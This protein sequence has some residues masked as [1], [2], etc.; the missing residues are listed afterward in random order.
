S[1]I[2]KTP[3][4]G[5]NIHEVRNPF[6]ARRRIAKTFARLSNFVLNCAVPQ[7]NISVPSRQPSS[8]DACDLSV[9]IVSWNVAGLLR[10]CLDALF[11]PEV[12]AGLR[13]EVIVV[14][15]AS[16]DDSAQVAAA[17]E[18]V[19]VVRNCRNIGY[20]SA[21]NIGFKLA[22]GNYLLVLNP[23]TVALPG[24]LEALVA[25]AERHTS[26]GIVAPRLLNPDG[27]I[28]RSAFRFPTLM[29]AFLDLFPLSRVV[30]GRLRNWISHSTING[31][32]PGE[33]TKTQPYR[34]DHPL[35]AAM[36]LRREAIEN[37]GGFDERL[38]MYSEE[39]DLAMRLRQVGWERWQVPAA[40]VIH[41]GG[42]STK[43][44]PD[45]MLRELWR[46]RLYIYEKHHD[47]VSGIFLH[48]LI[49]TAQVKESIVTRLGAALG[50][51]PI[52]E[53]NLR[54]RRARS[55]FRLALDMKR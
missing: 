37:V 54:L 16:S 29:M 53:A 26:A 45:R 24:S 20:G 38:F 3:R 10:D 11:S 22:R 15:N 55:L 43:Q 36:L 17:F 7:S 18:S 28:Q 5:K 1:V 51:M 30:P 32:Y 40:R 34:I 25:F 49:I 27:S 44:M 42:Q 21:N 46:S 14:D 6:R 47:P 19:R 4:V 39:V 9:V 50:T 33:P 41:L 52:K 8:H 31:R 2:R 13:M 23:D 35:G 12:S 48:T